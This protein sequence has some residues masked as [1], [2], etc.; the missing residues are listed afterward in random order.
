MKQHIEPPTKIAK[1]YSFK[2]CLHYQHWLKNTGGEELEITPNF[3]FFC[4]KLFII[5]LKKQDRAMKS[6]HNILVG[7]TSALIL[8]FFIKVP[9]LAQIMFTIY[10]FDSEGEGTRKWPNLAAIL[11]FPQRTIKNSPKF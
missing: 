5:N 1:G 8:H 7:F 4:Q 3:H 9:N 6:S 10:F 11:D 2:C